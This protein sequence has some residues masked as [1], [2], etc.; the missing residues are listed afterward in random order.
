MAP[1]RKRESNGPS[2]PIFDV[3]KHVAFTRWAEDRGVEINGVKA[4]NIPGRGIG[5][6]TTKRIG[7]GQR[8]LFI[9]AKAIYEPDTA[10]LRR[11]GVSS[12][13]PQ[14]QL[15]FSAALAFNSPDTGFKIWR[16]VWP[17][18]DDLEQ[19]MPMCWP[20]SH[21]ELLPSSAQ[22]PLSRQLADFNKDWLQ[23]RMTCVSHH[24]SRDG[25]KYFWMIVNS[26]SFHWKPSHSSGGMMV[27]CPFI[28]YM[29]HGPTGSGCMVTQSSDGYEVAA[30]RD[31]GKS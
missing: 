19:C 26:R 17:T 27:M 29:N 30:E 1:K 25:F 6:L 10:M 7:E 11:E 3:D 8:I 23:V 12:T 28:D 31:Y 2:L 4:A 13:S 18:R 14:A 20:T 9:P 5:L 22:Q 21:T 24:I 15:A 16:D